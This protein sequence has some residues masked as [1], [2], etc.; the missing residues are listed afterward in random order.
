MKTPN[1]LFQQTWFLLT[2]IGIWIVTYFTARGLLENMELAIGLRTIIAVLPILPF[3]FSLYL[4]FLQIRTLDELQM[5][6][7][8]DALALAFPLAMIL[9]MVLGLLGQALDL[10]YERHV[11]H[12]LPICYFIGLTVAQRRYQ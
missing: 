9:L 6:I 10:S 7:Q 8:L 12:Y 3:G 2:M 11:W 1:S 5:R 4:I